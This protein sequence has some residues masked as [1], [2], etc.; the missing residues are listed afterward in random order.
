MWTS[1]TEKKWEA[2]L[3]ET[4]SV[5]V[6]TDSEVEG[7][8]WA[9]GTG[10]SPDYIVDLDAGSSKKLESPEGGSSPYAL[11]DGWVVYGAGRQS[12]AVTLYEPD[13]TL[14]ETFLSDAGGS[15]DDYPWSPEPFTLDQARSW[16]KD[17]DTSWAP[18]TY[19]VSQ[20][21]AS[22]ESITVA[23]N[24]IDLGEDNSLTERKR[25]GCSVTSPIQVIY[26]A[27]DGQIAT[28]YE[29][30][31]RDDE[32]FLHLVDMATGRASDPIPLGDYSSYDVKNDVLIVHDEAGGIKAYRPA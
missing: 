30:R 20:A 17:G 9:E 21:D 3:P 4:T 13:G 23:G 25:G 6:L 14:R 18:G 28:F 22:C 29:H 2:E 12:A 8:A 27:G 10:K 31:Y 15:D 24:D 7:Y 32:V 26:H 11:A 1:L 5:R 16:L 19:S